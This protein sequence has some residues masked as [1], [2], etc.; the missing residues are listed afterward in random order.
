MTRAALQVEVHSHIERRATVLHTIRFIRFLFIALA[1]GVALA[2]A[3]ELPNKINL[4]RDDYQTVQQIYRGWALLGIIILFSA[5]SLAVKVR[6]DPEISGLTLAASLCIAAALIVFFN[7]YLSCQSANKQLDT[8]AR[9][10]DGSSKAMGILP[11]HS[12]RFIFNCLDFADSI[13]SAEKWMSQSLIGKHA[14]LPPRL[15]KR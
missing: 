3:L 1:L 10:L 6:H 5:L 12:R 15:Y 9:K 4:S 14:Y 2:H 13:G 7:I 8:I 11:R